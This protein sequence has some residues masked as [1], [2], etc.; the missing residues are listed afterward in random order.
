M[1]S[2]AVLMSLSV[3]L[4]FLVRF[5]GQIPAH[6]FTNIS[7]I[8]VL[9]LIVTIPIF[10]FSKLY[11]FTWLY[12]S[13]SELISL[14]KATF[15]SF[16][17]LATSFVILREQPI[18][19][20]FPRSTLFVTYFFVFLFCGGI[21][22]AKRIYLEI[23]SRRGK[24]EKERTLIVGAGDAGEQIL[25]GILNSKISPYLPVGFVDDNPAK[26]GILIH[27]LKVLGK[28]Q[29]LPKVVKNEKV[30]GL[31]VALPS[32]GSRTIVEA[33]GYGRE[34]GLRKIKIVPSL[35]E[36]IDG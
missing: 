27:G 25:R 7:A 4:A 13:T 12:V 36:I 35:D 3:F 26:Q 22:L 30:Q 21:R 8:I 14:A 28:I 10:Y 33:V 2:D 29:D 23:F 5:E 19:S 15:L 11:Y 31:I 18:F 9:L 32:A 6:Y 1:F 34:A 20:G 16:L 17:I 24:E